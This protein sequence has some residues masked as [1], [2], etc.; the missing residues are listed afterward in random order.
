MQFADKQLS[1]EKL[2]TIPYESILYNTTNYYKKTVWF[3][4]TEQNI[5]RTNDRRHSGE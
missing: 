5:P 1:N 4:D 2:K 3:M